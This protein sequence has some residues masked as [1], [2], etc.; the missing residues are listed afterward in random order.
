[1]TLAALVKRAGGVPRVLPIVRDDRALLRAAIEEARA[2]D[3]IVS[4]GGVSVGAHDHVKE[5]LAELGAELDLWRVAMKPGK[6]VAIARLDEVPYFGLPGNPVSAVV[7]FLLFVR[8]AL[9]TALGCA[10]PFDLPRARAI[11]DGPLTIKG[12][13]RSYLRAHLRFDAAGE[14]RARLMPHQGSHLVT[15]LLGA[16]GLVIVEP[17]A[18]AL[19]A[20]A[21][22]SAHVIGP[23]LS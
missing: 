12:E 8:P 7:A 11:L 23:L 16:N 13:R 19:S 20:G 4:T 9:R 10:Q 21:S 2:A 1:Y 3:L 17:G 14:L 18:H 6:P 5:V 22:V 15:S